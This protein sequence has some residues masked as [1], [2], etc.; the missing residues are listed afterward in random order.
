MNK[1]INCN[2]IVLKIKEELKEKLSTISEKLKLVVIQVGEDS[3]SDVYIRNKK[4]TCEELGIL[5]EHKKYTKINEMDLI[6]EIKKLN[7][8]TTVTGILVQLPLPD[9][10]NENKI[11]E[12]ISPLKDVDGLTSKNIGNLYSGN[13]ALIPCTALGIIKILEYLNIEFEGLNAVIV[14]RSKLVGLPLIKLLLNKDCTVTISHSKT[15]A[16]KENTKNADILIVAA[17]KKELITKEFIKEN[18]IV[19]DVGINRCKNKLYGDCNFNDLLEKCKYITPVP[20]GVGKLTVILLINNII[21]AYY[22]QKK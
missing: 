18:A 3:A 8:D 1:I 10:I 17:G 5:C 16:L 11:I 9:N 6:K 22:L 2:E 15:K 20:G 13:D 7:N 21:E 14:G 19:I 12:S 4:K